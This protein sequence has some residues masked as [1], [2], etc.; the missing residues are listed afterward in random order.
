MFEYGD[1]VMELSCKIVIVERLTK[2]CLYAPAQ[3]PMEVSAGDVT[4]CDRWA[5][6]VANE[7]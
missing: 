7:P 4:K 6:K 1:L 5:C 2:A 3:E